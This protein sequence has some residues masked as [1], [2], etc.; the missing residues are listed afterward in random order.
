MRSAGGTGDFTWGAGQSYPSQRGLSA[1]SV[2]SSARRNFRRLGTT[3]GQRLGRRA[4]GAAERLAPSAPCAAL[5]GLSL[6]A[7]IALGADDLDGRERL[8]RSLAR[9][10]LVSERFSPDA[11][12][13]IGRC[14]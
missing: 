7:E 5:D 8:A 4:R 13:G 9:P 2:A 11:L 6:H 10:A 1:G 3:V 14:C 12:S